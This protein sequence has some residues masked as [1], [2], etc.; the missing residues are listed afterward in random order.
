M[1]TPE[2]VVEKK[3]PVKDLRTEIKDL[4]GKL[5]LNTAV[6]KSDMLRQ[7]LDKLRYASNLIDAENVMGGK[8]KKEFKR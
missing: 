4:K 8:E 3:L 2:S 5:F 7:Y 1:E 6:M